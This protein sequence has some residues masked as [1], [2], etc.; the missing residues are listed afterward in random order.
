MGW[1]QE[2]ATA[3][4]LGAAVDTF[5]ADTGVADVLLADGDL[6]RQDG[7]T[8]EVEGSQRANVFAKWRFGEDGF[9]R[10]GD[11]EVGDDDPGGEPGAG[12]QVEPFVQPKV[13][14]EH[15]DGNPFAAQRVRPAFTG[16]AEFM[17]QGAGQREG[18]VHAEQVA[19]EEQGQDED[20]AIMDPDDD[21]G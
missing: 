15:T 14:D 9:Q 16:E 11:Q 1:E 2:R 21:G 8:D 12:P 10:E 5:F 13:D 18:A 4:W 20:A 19:G 6:Q 3:Q 7:G 17:G